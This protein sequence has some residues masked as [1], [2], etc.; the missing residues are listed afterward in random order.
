MPDRRV[1]VHDCGL[2]RDTLAGH[3]CACSGDVSLRRAKY[4]VKHGRA[5]WW[6]RQNANGNT[7]IVRDAVV[8]VTFEASPLPS[9]WHSAR[10]IS[11][12]DVEAAFVYDENYARTRI[13]E[14]GSRKDEV[15]TDGCP[16]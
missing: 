4:L 12:K 8:L 15:T 9:D 10:S 16:D 14:F 2:E 11:A 1:I 6:Q 3:G 5:R 7:V 13:E